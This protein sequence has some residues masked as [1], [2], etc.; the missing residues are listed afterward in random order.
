MLMDT[1]HRRRLLLSR[2]R[3]AGLICMLGG[4]SGLIVAALVRDAGA[5]GPSNIVL[6]ALCLA[7]G[8]ILLRYARLVSDRGVLMVAVT[9]QILLTTVAYSA[10]AFEVATGM[11]GY[12]F[13]WSCAF[14]AYYF[15]WRQ[16]VLHVLGTLAL[17]GWWLAFST[18][19]SIGQAR[20][21]AV[22]GLLTVF[23]CVFGVL[24][25]RVDRLIA[26]LERDL[27]SD[28]LTG[29]LNRRGFFE[30]ATAATL[31]AMRQ[32][33]SVTVIA[34]DL[35]HFKSL[36]DMYGHAAGDQALRNFGAL[37]ERGRH[38]G[39]QA[40]RLGGE[41]FCILL[42]N[43]DIDDARTVAR[44][45][46]LETQLMPAARPIT[47]SL[48]LAVMWPGEA[49]DPGR[50]LDELLSRADRALYEAKAS[51]R[52]RFC[53]DGSMDSKTTGI[54]GVNLDLH[55]GGFKPQTSANS[56]AT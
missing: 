45:L 48:G 55:P 43:T 50:A 27:R 34:A 16:S 15:P 30:V 44:R 32:G 29:V 42:R 52:N 21:V 54:A 12:A 25:D 24:R 11:L 19:A 53:L 40:G 39:E 10:M 7:V 14:V 4:G 8:A 31:D 35:D 49:E 47:V 2:N 28:S 5:R 3:M 56:A 46:L 18:P 1:V 36:N 51:G 38:A 6:F 9:G 23:A 13:I 17:Y 26:E 22:A 37:L 33:G 41:E 20:W